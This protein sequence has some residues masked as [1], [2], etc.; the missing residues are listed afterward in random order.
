MERP[1]EGAL[2]CSSSIE[3]QKTSWET[4]PGTPYPEPHTVHT[5]TDEETDWKHNQA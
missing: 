2:T 3:F 1:F 5:L 4:R